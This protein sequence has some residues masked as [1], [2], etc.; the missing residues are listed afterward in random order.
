MSGR[1]R[2]GPGLQLAQVEDAD[3]GDRVDVMVSSWF[4]HPKEGSGVRGF[5]DS[6]PP[7]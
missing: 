1:G 5:L 7:L 3:G 4:I 6:T 2:V